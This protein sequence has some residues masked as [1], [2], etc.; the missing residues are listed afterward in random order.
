[1]HSFDRPAGRQELVEN[2]DYDRVLPK[3]HARYQLGEL[4]FR[5]VAAKLG[6]SVRDLYDLLEQKGVANLTSLRG[7]DKQFPMSENQ[8][9]NLAEQLV[10]FLTEMHGI[11]LDS[12]R[13]A[14]IG[15]SN[16][17]RTR[18]VWVRLFEDVQHELFPHIMPHSRHWVEEHFEPLLKDKHFMD[19]NPV[20]MN[21]DIAC[22]HLLWNKTEGKLTG[23]IDFGTA[24]IGDPASDYAC[25]IYNY[26]ET[27][28]ARMERYYPAIQDAV[29]RAR[30]W[31]GTLE[32]QWAL[33]GIRR[34][35]PIWHT[36][37][38]GN[39]KDM[40]PIGAPLGD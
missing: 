17:N 34:K 1:M 6:L 28:L 8:Q 24:G 14:G 5:A 31:A 19:Y 18:E 23:G 9:D 38:V 39:A 25:V 26:G 21:G 33:T 10:E 40:Y 29:D 20:L 13:A 12:V 15:D 35:S 37:H 30:F 4:S 27:F 7:T 11:P 16:V 2:D 36:V 22:Y 32:L 3:L